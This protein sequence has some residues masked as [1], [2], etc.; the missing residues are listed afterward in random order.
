[1]ER[2]SVEEFA[3]MKVRRFRHKA[4]QL[5]ATIVLM[6]VSAA[7]SSRSRAFAQE[8]GQQ[9]TAAAQAADGEAEPFTGTFS[10]GM[11]IELVGLSMHPSQG[12]PWWTPDGMIMT[13]PPYS[14]NRRM[15][16]PA[17]DE[18]ALEICWRW[19]GFPPQRLPDAK[20]DFDPKA[21]ARQ[22]IL[23]VDK[24][25]NRLADLQAAAVTV[26]R[27]DDGLIRFSLPIR[28]APAEPPAYESI[29]FR[30]LSLILGNYERLRVYR[31]SPD[32]KELRLPAVGATKALTEQQLNSPEYKANQERIRKERALQKAL[33]EQ[34]TYQ[35]KE[36]ER[37][38][39]APPPF[40]AARQEY[41]S[42]QGATPGREPNPNRLGFMLFQR[43]NGELDW[44]SASFTMPTIGRLL[45]RVFNI[46]S[47]RIEGGAS[48]L[49]TEL[50]GDWV[51][52]WD[53]NG[54]ITGD[55]QATYVATPED[56]DAFERIVQE[57]LIEVVDFELR[58]MT[59]PVY[60]VKGTYKYTK[61]PDPDG[62]MR[63]RRSDFPDEI[64]V[65]AGNRLTSGSFISYAEL[66]ELIGEFLKVPLVDEVTTR[67]TKRQMMLNIYGPPRG[68][69]R[70]LDQATI[71]SALASLTAQTGYTFS[72][73]ERPVKMLFI[74]RGV[75]E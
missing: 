11:K 61:V 73:E 9:P 71:D 25:G 15:L 1:V 31:V 50:P 46:K 27:E 3:M 35:L 59:R 19:I 47:H 60:V 34:P 36:G 62:K 72:K 32:G 8:L 58:E 40:S 6:M 69:A 22:E 53:P 56:I 51:L 20:W 24:D 63:E 4:F 13:K 67:P 29:E 54:S 43:V 75:R 52:T 5:H 49:T 65:L 70:P 55:P 37:F 44:K 39:H 28:G 2:K 66:L 64:K 57:E 23:P 17:E 41:W 48:L 30:G 7:L 26:T 16:R 42:L 45:D 10:T 14:Q 33:G 74:K 18:F 68:E 38:K 21:K 12:Q